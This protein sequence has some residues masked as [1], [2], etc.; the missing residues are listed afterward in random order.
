MSRRF[1]W[2]LWSGF[3]LS[4]GAFVSYV[5]FFIRFPITRDMPWLTLVL[6]AIA[7]VLM[8]IGLRKA[9]GRR[10]VAWI[11]TVLGVGV[12][13]FFCVLI[14]IGPTL[15]PASTNAPGVGAK[16]PDFVLLDTNRRPVALAQLLAEPETKGVILIFYRGYW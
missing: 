12:C 15:L 16:A 4:V 11:I 3:A 2:Q 1:N 7:I 6:F 5:F 8:V 13:A 14:L 9:A 10:I